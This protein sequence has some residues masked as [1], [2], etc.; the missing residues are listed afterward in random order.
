MNE[1]KPSLNI[2]KHSRLLDRLVTHHDRR[3]RVAA[4]DFIT[5]FQPPADAP[6]LK[7]NLIRL[8]KGLNALQDDLIFANGLEYPTS[9]IS[10]LVEATERME[11]D[12]VRAT[13]IPTSKWLKKFGQY[14]ALVETVNDDIESLKALGA[15]FVLSQLTHK[16]IDKKFSD[17]VRLH[18]RSP[19]SERAHSA[20]QKERTW[21]S[22]HQTHLKKI[23]VLTGCSTYS[24]F[25]EFQ[26]LA[27]RHY[28]NDSKF[29]SRAERRGQADS[30]ALTENAFRDV[31]NAL[32]QR[33]MEFSPLAT[34][35]CVGFLSGLTWP[36]VQR[37]PLLAPKTDD[38]VIWLD[39]DQGC[40]HI[41][42][43]PIARGAAAA[44]GGEKYVPA[45]RIFCRYLPRSVANSLQF[46]KLKKPTEQM[47]GSMCGSVDV[48]PESDVYCRDDRRDK[49]SIA[50]LYNTRSSISNM[51][52]ISGV[53]TAILLGCFERIAH[54]KLFYNATN[55]HEL[56]AAIFALQTLL[57]W[58]DI[59]N[60]VEKEAPSIGASVVPEVEA[61]AQIG[62]KLA[63]AVLAAQPPNNYRWR[64]LKTFHNKFTDYVIFVVSLSGMGRD[65]EKLLI[66]AISSVYSTGLTGLH[67]K[68]TSNSLGGSPVV[69]AEIVRL[70]VKAYLKHLECLLARMGKLKIECN[71]IL[72]RLAQ[73]MTDQDVDPFFHIGKHDELETRG[74]A[75]LYRDLAGRLEIKPDGARH[76]WESLMS[77]DG[78]PDNYSD[79]QARHT[80]RHAP[81]WSSASTL[82]IDQMQEC[83]SPIQDRMFKQ[84]GIELVWGL[85][86]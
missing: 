30:R 78:A 82:A 7:L 71:P 25:T 28:I 59:P 75:S 27:T 76:F 13:E 31:A 38:W 70:Q 19:N 64:H 8:L 20:T 24:P 67:D 6:Y 23:K 44:R 32:G 12:A 14:A 72:E 74:T 36:L 22:N 1:E 50:R 84:L 2:L 34:A 85:R 48:P 47:L 86:K 54:S 51:L 61:L 57:N 16:P 52:C 33:L 43:N 37:I 5:A 69:L 53:A 3:I 81:Y 15:A 41:N 73:I 65:R 26:E 35:I 10:L 79:A 17:Q 21:E 66:Q 18:S 80:V 29:A 68:V 9:T 56:T 63:S 42:L 39:I 40:F 58:G 55:P 4:A 46:L 62:L 83:L 49:N 77:L 60:E 45:T 11:D